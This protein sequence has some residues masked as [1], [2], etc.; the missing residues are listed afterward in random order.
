MTLIFPIAQ[1]VLSVL[2]A[3]V[4]AYTGYWRHAAYWLAAAVLTTSVTT[5]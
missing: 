5:L 1:I 2:A 3:I 4:Y